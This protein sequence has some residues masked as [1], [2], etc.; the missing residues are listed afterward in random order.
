MRSRRR[1]KFVLFMLACMGLATGLALYALRDN[2]SYFYTPH[3]VRAFQAEK[4]P[5]VAPGR[6][7]R[8]G[9]L[10]VKGSLSKPDA[11]G[12][13]RFTV[14]DNVDELTVRYQGILP[15]LFR[16]GQ[17]VVAT[18]SLDAKGV[19]AAS[20]LLAKHDETYMPPEVAKGLK[21]AHEAGKAGTP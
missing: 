18:G 16:E 19:F 2:L 9:G 14:T 1:L 7:F 5:R 12:A 6:V 13:I 3:E 11:E 20:G 4:S 17:G 21:R 15:D 10:V 8:L